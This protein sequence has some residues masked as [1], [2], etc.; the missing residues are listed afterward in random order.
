M[1]FLAD[2]ESWCTFFNKE[3]ALTLV[4]RRFVLS[5]KDYQDMLKR[6]QEASRPSKAYQEALKRIQEAS[7]PS[8]MFLKELERAEQLRRILKKHAE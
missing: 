4:A 8:E 1:K 6:I 7:R 5:S 3:S 2:G